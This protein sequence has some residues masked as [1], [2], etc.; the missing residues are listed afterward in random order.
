MRTVCNAV[1]Y[2]EFAHVSDDRRELLFGDLWLGRHVA[3]TP[4]VLAHAQF[5]GE[6]EGA[7]GMVPRS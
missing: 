6:K 7:I 5:G 1:R 2:L 4:M 3:E